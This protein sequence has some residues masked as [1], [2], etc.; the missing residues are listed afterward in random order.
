VAFDEFGNFANGD[1]CNIGTGA[2]S[3]LFP[4]RVVV[5]GGTPNYDYLTSVETSE[6]LQSVRT[7]KRHITV[8][9]TPDGKLYTYIRYPD[10]TFQQVTNG[11][12][13]PSA[14]GTLKLGWVAGT[15][16]QNNNHEIS[17]VK[18]VKPTDLT[19]AVTDG[20][21]SENRG[22]TFNWTATV[23]NNGANPVTGATDALVRV[24]EEL[25]DVVV[26]R[27]FRRRVDAVD[28]TDLHAGVV[29]H[30]DAGLGDDVGHPSASAGIVTTRT[31]PASSTSK[32][33]DGQHSRSAATSRSSSARTPS[34]GASAMRVPP[35][36]G[37]R[38]VAARRR[39]RSQSALRVR[40]S[41]AESEQAMGTSKLGFAML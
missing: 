3:G 31:P 27:L 19:T 35:A 41:V 13:L 32:S 20:D 17:G 37:V 22:G 34:S 21:T 2:G 38:V 11:Y 7:Q 6:G 40:A 30:V 16:G 29:L 28:R 36:T 14:P 26:V 8:A 4:D 15:G 12:Q 25:A 9:V 1:F 18:V 39:S 23:T 24:D 33:R 5:R 10:G